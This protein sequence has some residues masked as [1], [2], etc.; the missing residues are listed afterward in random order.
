MMNG[1]LTCTFF[2]LYIASLPAAR[3]AVEQ[4]EPEGRALRNGDHRHAQ[5]DEF[6]QQEAKPVRV[7]AGQEIG[8]VARVVEWTDLNDGAVGRGRGGRKLPAN[9]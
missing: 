9:R 7:V 3:E 8:K 1:G 5:T 2:F 6:A 4:V